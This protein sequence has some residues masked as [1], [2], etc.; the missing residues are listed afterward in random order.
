MRCTLSA[1]AAACLSAIPLPAPA[2]EKAAPDSR[3][4]RAGHVIPDENYCDQPYV[5]VTRDGN[6][7]CTLTTGPFDES[8][9]RQHVVAAISADHGRTWSGLIDIEPPGEVQSSWVV[10]LVTPGGRVYAFYNYNGDHVRQLPRAPHVATVLGWYVYKFSDDHGRTWSKER[11]RLPMRLTACDR[12]NDWQGK[13]QMFWGIDKPNVVGPD[14]VFAFTKLGRHMLELGEGWVYR[15]DNVL[16]ERDPAKLRWELLPEGDHGIRAP[17]FGSVQ[18][19]HNIVP[20]ADGSLYCVYRTT[21][22]HPCHAYSRDGGRAWEKPRPMT[23][24]P[25]GR[26]IKHPRAC[27]MV[28][29]TA[30]GKFLFWFHNHGGRTYEGRNPA[31]I[32]GGVER[33]G[34]IHWSQPEIL[35]YD[36]DPKVRMSYPDLIEQDGRYWVTETQKTVA[37]VHEIDKTLL[38][39]LWGQGQAKDVAR[40]GLLVELGADELKTVEAR[41]PRA[42]GLAEGAGLAIELWLRF[43]TVAAGQVVLDSRAP[44]GRGLALTT[45]GQGALRIELSD[46]GEQAAWETDPGALRPGKLHHVVVN[47]DGGPKIIT[48]VVD[49]VLCDGGA[50][51]PAGWTRFPSGLDDVS[52]TGALRVGASL[53]GRV[54]LL[55]VYGRYLRTSE[56]VAHFHAGAQPSH[57]MR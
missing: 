26:T 40:D 17:E 22:G 41:L 38:E 25:G 8:G 13:V 37:R 30:G 54:E 20:L 7:L 50:A 53:K 6:W 3:N 42:P 16:T 34:R 18:E 47:V 15:S 14:A 57:F 45:A 33:E 9:P 32:A 11:S 44:D 35:L 29:R 5:V 51:R 49:G 21:L 28:W 52:G 31:W 12:A 23:Y 4:V 46:G 55:R 1:V 10:P 39:G 43:E 48:F 56:A 19:E 27:P 2:A 36:G 24:A